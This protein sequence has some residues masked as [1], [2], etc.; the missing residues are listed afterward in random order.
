MNLKQCISV[1]VVLASAFSMR[2]QSDSSHAVHKSDTLK[3]IKK[4]PFY[5]RQEEILFDGKR[6]KLYSNYMTGGPLIASSTIRSQAQKG[7][8]IDFNWH[9]RRR[10]FQTGLMMSGLDFGDNNHISGHLTIA[11]RKEG[12]YYSLAGFVGACY[13]YGVT[14]DITTGPQFYN[15]FGGYAS[16]Q[17]V[18]KFNYD[19]GLGLE[20]FTEISQNQTMVGA[21]LIAFFSG[22]YK[23]PKRN[24][25]PNVRA[26]NPKWQK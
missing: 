18:V 5:Y 2:A 4:K 21:K 22:A 6:Y 16:L 12:N 3:Q 25:N 9:I 17:Y 20:A 13:S 7:I 14:G 23:G 1:L 26:E 24:Y 10:F 15:V 11:Q 19:L 8:G